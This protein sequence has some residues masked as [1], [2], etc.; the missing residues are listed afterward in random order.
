MIVLQKDMVNQVVFPL[1][2]SEVGGPY[3]FTFKN[4]QDQKSKIFS[5]EPTIADFRAPV[6]E[7]VL[8]ETPGSED[9]P[10]GRIYFDIGQ[11]D[12]TVKDTTGAVL[13]HNL[14]RVD[15]NRKKPVTYENSVEFIV[16]G[17]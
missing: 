12:C 1:E 8:P 3:E 15:G 16:Y 9:I 10:V 6:F 2:L 7:W 11:Y 14:I 4:R 5:A 13:Y 17:R